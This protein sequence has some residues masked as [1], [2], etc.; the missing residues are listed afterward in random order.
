MI[1]TIEYADGSKYVG[2]IIN[3]MK[4]CQGTLTGY[5][6]SEGLTYEGEWKNDKLHG[7]GTYAFANV[8]TYVGEFKNGVIDGHGTLT[9]YAGYRYN[10]RGPDIKVKGSV[11]DG[12]FKDSVSHG[13]GTCTYDD[14]SQEE[15]IFENGIYIG[16]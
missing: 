2:E 11:Y 6:I 12:E 8:E 9:Q 14:G 3:E 15:G 13:Q 4:N 10:G 16:K 7:Q 5:G 1:K